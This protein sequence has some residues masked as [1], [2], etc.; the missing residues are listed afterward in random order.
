MAPIVQRL[1]QKQLVEN[2]LKGVKDKHKI[3]IYENTINEIYA[4]K[5]K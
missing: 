4:N 2:W 3:E 5:S 1:K